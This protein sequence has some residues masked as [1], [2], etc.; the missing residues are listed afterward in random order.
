MEDARTRQLPRGVLGS[1]EVRALISRARAGDTA[2]RQELIERNLRLVASVAR[3]FTAGGLEY[4]DVFQ[5]GCIGLV[6]AINRFNPDFDVRFSTYAVPVIMGEIRQYVREQHP[7]RLGR[8]LHELARRVAAT[9]EF[10]AQKLDRQPTAAEI[11]AELSV[12]TEDVVIALEAA[13][14]VASLDEPLLSADPDSVVLGDV[15]ASAA[16]FSVNVDNV[17]LKQALAALEPW[18]RRLI[19]LRFF[20]DKPQ[21]EVARLLGVSQAHVSRS[22]QRILRR[23]REFLGS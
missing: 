12:D 20:A 10:L 2:A 19:L 14:P 4:D 13:L 9:R 8:T 17:V 16:P 18:E 11:A 15:I 3:R 23:F 22:E 7:L 5:V 21:T 1:D 6:K